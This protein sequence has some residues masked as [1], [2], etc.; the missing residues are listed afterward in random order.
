MHR[1]RETPNT[2]ANT[3][4]NLED[5]EAP[6]DFSDAST[7]GEI[8]DVNV[9]PAEEENDDQFDPGTLE[10]LYGDDVCQEDEWSLD[11]GQYDGYLTD[12]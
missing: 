6:R 12:A 11:E 4:T 1:N 8:C 10:E 5:R 2:E 9:W 7:R 3:G